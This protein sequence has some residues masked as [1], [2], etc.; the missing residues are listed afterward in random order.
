MSR[1]PRP[2]DLRRDW[3]KDDSQTPIL[4]VDMDAFFVAVE[5]LDKPHLRGKPLAVGGMD[6]G[7]ISTASYEARRYG[8]NSAMPV[9]KARRL[10]PQLIILPVAAEKYRSVSAQIMEILQNISPVFE[11]VSIDEAFLDVRGVR[12]LFGSPLEIGVKIRTAI[13]TQVGV[14]A[15]VGIAS[16]KHLAKIASAQAK[17]DGLLLVPE[18]ESLNFLHQLP[19]GALNGVG[20]KT[21][22]KLISHGVERVGDL[23]M[24]GEKNL[25]SL[26]GEAMGKHLYALAMNEDKRPV[27]PE[28]REKSISKEATFF[29]VLSTPAAVQ[30]VLLEQSHAV[31]RRLRSGGY[32][33]WTISI[34]VRFGNFQTCSRSL[35]LGAPTDLGADIYT[36][37]QRLFATLPF[38]DSGIRLLGVRAQQLTSGQSGVQLAFG[39]DERQSKAETAVDA[40]RRRFGSQSVHPGSLVKEQKSENK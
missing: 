37:A 28:T 2:V 10:C 1:G 13:H 5:L 27:E 11:Q 7:V 17:P 18:S 31:A 32:L 40:I 21:Q 36:A 3:G 9:G 39:A 30:P 4:H 24:L 23:A 15:S 34:K 12:R 26:L 25:I 8:V 16:T 22:Q 20:G 33:A 14:A 35:T 19:V 38:P 29:E 6:R